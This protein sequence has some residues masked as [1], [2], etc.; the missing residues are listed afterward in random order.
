MRP[1]Y[2]VF[3]VPYKVRKYSKASIEI[4]FRFGCNR[5]NSFSLTV[6][7]ASSPV[8]DDGNAVSL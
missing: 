8:A 5:Q 3:A 1:D 7:E 6:G 2:A 4:S